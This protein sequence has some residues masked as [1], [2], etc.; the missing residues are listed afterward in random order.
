MASRKE[1]KEAL[2]RER[3]EREAQA[4]TEH[5]RKQMMGYG[6]AGAIVLAV[7]VVIGVFVVG[8][9][10]SDGE[11]SASGGDVY[12]SGGSVPAQKVTDLKV[13]AADA[14]CVLKSDPNDSSKHTQSLDTRVKYRTNPPTSGSHYIQPPSDGAYT[15]PLQDEQFVHSQEHG[16]IVIWFK[17][18]LPAKDRADLKALF[19]EDNYQMVLTPRAKMP[20]QVAATAWNAAPGR[21]GTGKLLLCDKYKAPQVFDAIRS[22]RDENRGNGPEPVP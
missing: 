14:G 22:F 10:G 1:Q 12:P 7:V 18:T 15:T 3:E 9:G 20:Y 13:A 11:S 21:E 2:R 17:P 4:R 19:D 5:R 6:I 16:R 8:S